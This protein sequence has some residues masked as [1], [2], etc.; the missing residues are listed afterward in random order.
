MAG[1]PPKESPTAS[2]VAP[3]VLRYLGAQG[4]DPAEVASLA[5]L[6]G[7]GEASA[8][9]SADQ[10]PITPGGMAGLLRGAAELLAEPHLSLR[11]PAELP[12]RRYDPLSLGARAAGTPREVLSLVTE[13]APLLLPGLAARTA[14]DDVGGV[15]FDATFTGHPRGLGY[16]VDAFLLATVLGHCRRGGVDRATAPSRAWLAAARPHALEPLLSSL[17][18]D[19]VELGAETT[20]FSLPASAADHPLPGADDL[21]V[22]TATQLA[23][24]ALAAAPRRGSFATAVASRIEAQLGA[25]NAPSAEEV[26]DGLRMSARTLQRRL[27]DEGARFSAITDAVRERLARRLLADPA[28]GL[29]EIAYRS[30]FTDLATFSRAFKRWTGLPPG[31]YRKRAPPTA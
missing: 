2:A 3:A 17:G 8:I 7:L 13:F 12:F 26:A 23:E 6:A 25:G 30:G 16:A 5:A 20:G 14:V 19:D 4:V 29:G 10:A 18:T 22:A 24:V 11:L 21:L 15:R 28:L 1:R 31:A 27:D 9:A